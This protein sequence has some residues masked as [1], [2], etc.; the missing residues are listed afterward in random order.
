M[1]Q[2]HWMK[3]LFLALGSV[4]GFVLG[5]F[6]G[7][8][9]EAFSTG[10][11]PGEKVALQAKSGGGAIKKRRATATRRHAMERNP[12]K[13]MRQAM[14]ILELTPL[15]YG[16]Y[17]TIGEIY[18][19]ISWMTPEDVRQALGELEADN[20]NPMV[21][22]VL[23]GMLLG[24]RARQD[25]TEA[26]EHAMKIKEPDLRVRAVRSV[27]GGWAKSDPE[28]AY[29]WCREA[30][31]SAGDLSLVTCAILAKIAQDNL[32][33][34]FSLLKEL[35]EAEQRVA[36]GMMADTAPSDGDGRDA[37][38]AALD[39]IEN[40]LV[41]NSGMKRFVI[42]WAMQHPKDAARFVE[43]REW[44]E[45]TVEDLRDRVADVWMRRDPK[46]AIE[47]R[48][49]GM[50]DPETRDEVLPSLFARWV[51]I[52]PNT[53]VEWLAKQP[54]TFRTDALYREA[55]ERLM[56]CSDFQS[57]ARWANQIKNKNTRHYKIWQIHRNW[58]KESEAQA[59]KWFQDLDEETR[60][61]VEKIENST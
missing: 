1:I 61:G 28:A 41:R 56:G 44:E 31:S 55:T 60:V 11:S 37:L 9:C 22:E 58:K 19:S 6:E 34:G 40:P 46:A 48:I 18:E 17:D 2:R 5:W 25:P 8:R 51:R 59:A 12:A 42:H 39:G 45:T 35:P 7:K 30:K 29:A 32:E 4:I 10:E 54:E 3:I 13:S 43:S 36:I 49:D 50:D 52:A 47:W 21:Q 53:A 15:F 57:A 27:L 14:Q 23:L 26:M 20:R 33:K 24:R 16:D 38:L